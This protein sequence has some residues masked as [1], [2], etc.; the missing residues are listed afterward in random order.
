MSTKKISI[1]EIVLWFFVFI[2]IIISLTPFA[3]GFKIKSDYATLI[4]DVSELSQLDVEIVNYDQGLFSSAVTLSVKIP[5]APEQVLFKE[6]VIHGP[7]YLGLLSQGKSPLVVAVIKGQLDMASVQKTFIQQIFAGNNPLKYQTII[8][9]AGD[10]AAQFYIP[11]VDTSFSDE[12]G[13]VYVL[14]SGVIMNE[15]Y[16]S[17]TGLVKGDLQMPS[18]KIKSQMMAMNAESISM[19]FSGS[20]GAN[21]IM[22]GDSVVSINLLD[23]DSG[24][25]QFA[26]KD[27]VLHSVS[28]DSAGLINT[29]TRVDARELLASNQKFGPLVL[30]LSVNGI[31]AESLNQI[32]NVQSE[33][34]EKLEQGLPPEQVN[35]M[36]TGQIMSIVPDL[37]KQAE[38][39]LNPLSIHSEL[40]K[41]EADM[42][43]TLDGI[44]SDTPADPMFLLGAISLDLNLSIDEQL[45][46]Q[47]IRWEL[48]NNLQANI[49]LGSEKS[50]KMES[51]IPMEQ[52][53][54]E[55]IQG[56][57]DESWL[58]M[59]EGVY[60]SKISMHQGELLI[61]NK[62]VDP[63]QQI[64]SSMGEA[65]GGA[66]AQQSP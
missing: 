24:E 1:A 9:F 6:E 43:F 8:N 62:P 30:D 11:A 53:V 59:N 46:K 50:K 10:V 26:V 51:N 31:N 2:L 55:N 3:L 54:S 41:L 66:A 56:M 19:S 37:I 40:G 61:N 52:K 16:S 38:L 5:N 21:D 36:M 20:M 42:D 45:L 63:M 65:E 49:Q 58:V 64:M 14:S 4:E 28:A 35:A 22:V 32:Q 7:L 33:V 34:E 13:P 29:N 17:T 15:Y 39:K 12:H 48:E 57:I 25:E 23:I 18:F 44:N 27:L 47:F 60:I